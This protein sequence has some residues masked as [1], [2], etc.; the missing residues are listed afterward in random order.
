M[1][2]WILVPAF[3]V[4]GR[5]A[6]RRKGDAQ[7][8]RQRSKILAQAYYHLGR[9]AI[10]TPAGYATDNEGLALLDRDLEPLRVA[11]AEFAEHAEAQGSGRRV[12]VE[13]YV[14]QPP[15]TS[16]EPWASRF[17][18]AIESTRIERLVDL[19]AMLAL[20][21]PKMV[22]RALD[23]CANLRHLEPRAPEI[24]AAVREAKLELARAAR[25]GIEPG[26]QVA[27]AVGKLEE[28]LECKP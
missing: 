11:A 7:L 21:D 2:L 24:L 4:S 27:T 12:G 14:Y 5:A 15:T 22:D 17:W 8:L 3:S 23:A 16:P 13:V 25:R 20:G 19:R 1:A 10:S 28:A 26:Q 18:E 9:R 6:P